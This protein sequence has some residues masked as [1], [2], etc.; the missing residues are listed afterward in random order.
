[1]NTYISETPPRCAGSYRIRD[2]NGFIV[3]W[4]DSD[5]LYDT[6]CVKS[7]DGLFANNICF[8]FILQDDKSSTEIKTN[9]QI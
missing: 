1:M 2:A 5:N 9:I 3:F 6:W 7:A 8:E 4:G